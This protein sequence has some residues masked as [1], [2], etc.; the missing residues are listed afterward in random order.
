[1]TTKKATKATATTLTT[2]KHNP[3]VLPVKVR[4]DQEATKVVASMAVG[5]IAGNA[6]LVQRFSEWGLGKDMVSLEG[7]IEALDST[8]IATHGGDLKK[9]ESLLVAQAST[10]NAI[11]CEMARRAA[12]NLG[13]YLNATDTYLR[14]ALKAQTQ[15]RATLETLAAIKNPPVVF[16][17]QFNVAHGAQQVNNAPPNF[18]EPC[19]TNAL[20]AESVPAQIPEPSAPALAHAEI[21]KMEQSELIGRAER[22]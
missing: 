1:M 17:R 12:L 18:G 11:F 9:A 13:E 3:A 6:M 2:A 4:P 5:G 10:L 14:L 21:S 8:A 16:A 20:P 15:C 7:C 22:G 19:Q